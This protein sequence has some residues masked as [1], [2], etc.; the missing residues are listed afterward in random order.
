MTPTIESL[1]KELKDKV[2]EIG[3]LLNQ[4]DGLE[5]QVI[6]VKKLMDEQASTIQDQRLTILTLES[7]MKNVINC[8]I[9]RGK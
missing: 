8:V 4:I 5:N 3:K 6:H 7:T 9:N 1:R 2:E